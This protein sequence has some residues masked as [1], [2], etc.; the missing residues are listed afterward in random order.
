MPRFKNLPSD[1][2]LRGALDVVSRLSDN[3]D[4]GYRLGAEVSYRNQYQARG[5]YVV[6]GPTGSGFSFGGGI[7]T[8][9]LQIDLARFLSESVA[10]GV[11]PPTF[12]TLRYLF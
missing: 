7:S 8:G 1:V 3:G 4:L 5:G 11:A 2:R 10:P 6:N 12:L 9:K